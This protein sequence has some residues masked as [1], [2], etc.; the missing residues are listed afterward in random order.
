MLCY[1]PDDNIMMWV[2]TYFLQHRFASECKYGRLITF[3]LC[4]D[5]QIGLQYGCEAR[6]EGYLRNMGSYLAEKNP[7]NTPI[8]IF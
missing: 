7:L 5:T 8:N 3:A 1:R 4:G 6:G 2:A